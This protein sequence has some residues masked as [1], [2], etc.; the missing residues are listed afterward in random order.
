MSLF[1]PCAA[2]L[3]SGTNFISVLCVV[4]KQKALGVA[5]KIFVDANKD[6]K[7]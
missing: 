2:Q 7:L 4:L 1:R 5:G 3:G 6:A